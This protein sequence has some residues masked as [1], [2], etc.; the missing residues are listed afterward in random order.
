[1]AYI[2]TVSYIHMVIIA[3]HLTVWWLENP[4]AYFPFP[5]NLLCINDEYLCDDNVSTMEIGIDATF[6]FWEVTYVWQVPLFLLHGNF[7]GLCFL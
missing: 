7:F 6:P 4:T 1:M 3:I 5:I 2:Y